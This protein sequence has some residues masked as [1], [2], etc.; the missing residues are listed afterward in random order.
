MP[1]SCRAVLLTCIF[2]LALCPVC[3][4][5][6]VS[7]VV[8]AAED[9]SGEQVAFFETRIRPVLVAHCYECHSASAPVPK[10]GLLLDSRE[11]LR[12]GGDSGPVITLEDPSQSL[13][14]SAI[15][16]EGLEMPPQRRLP[17][18]AAADFE[19][20]IGLGAP[21]P[22]TETSLRNTP[23]IDYEK[24]LRFWAFQQP[25][26]HALP[27]VQNSAWPLNE[28]DRFV[29]RA[30]EQRGLRPAARADSRA[31]IRRA[32]FDLIGLPPAPEAVEQFAADPSPAAWAE[33]I[34]RLL[35]SPHYGERWGRYWLDLA[36]YAEDQAHTFKAR[37]YPQGYLY[38]DWVVGALNDDMPYD[39]FL[40][41]QIAADQMDVR[42]Q[43]RHRA[44]LGL[45][46][47]GPVYYQDNGEQDKALADEWD[48]R[49]D[50][51]M[52][53]TQGLTVGCARCHDHKY[54]PISMADYYGLAGIFAS[55]E[56]REVPV[57]ADDVV[58]ARQSADVAMQQQTLQIHRLLT[59]HA[60]AA[61]LRL[62][63]AIPPYLMT[64]W[65]VRQV[66]REQPQDDKLIETLAKQNNLNSELLNRWVAWLAEQ[67][68][69][70]AVGTP[71][72]Y[73]DAWRELVRHEQPDRD[74]SNDPA[75]VARVTAVAEQMQ[76]QVAALIPHRQTLRQQFGDDFAFVA[77]EDRVVIA[78]GTV[79]LGNLFDDRA[80]TTLRSA[81]ATDRFRSVATADSP[82]VDRIVQGW[83]R[84]TEIAAGIHFDFTS[85]GSDERQFGQI[86][87]DGW[88]E[89]GGI[90]TLGQRCESGLERTE[91]GIGIH[92][93]ALLTLDLDE[94]RLA[95]LI[96]PDQT[97]RFR[98]DRA[99]LNDDSLGDGGSVHVAV[100]ISRPHRKEDTYDAIL[101]GYVNGHRATVAENDRQYYFDGTLPEPLLAD[102]RF[103]SFDIELGPEARYLTIVSTG[104]GGSAAENSINSDHAVLSGARLE[105]VPHETELTASAATAA[106]DELP[107]EQLAQMRI[108]ATLLSE[109]FDD[110][111]VLALPAPEIGPL[112]D[113]EPAEQLRNLQ[114]DLESLRK[115]AESIAVTMAHS[116]TDGDSRDLPI[117][118]AGDPKKTGEPAPRGFPAVFTTGRRVPFSPTGSGRRELAAAVTD[119]GNPLTARVIAN[120]VWAGHFGSGIVRTLN[121]FGQLGDRPSHPELLDFLALELQL[122]GWSLKSL[123][124][125]I[126]L[127]AT[128]QQNCDGEAGSSE[129]DPENRLLWRTNRRRLD[130]EAWRDAVLSAAGTLDRT[131][132]GPSAELHESNRRR[133]LYGQISRHQLNDLL[134][135]FDFPDPNITA[136]ERTV[137]TVPLQQLF[138][139]NSQFVVDQARALAARLMADSPQDGARVTQAFQLLFGRPPSEREL[140]AALDFLQQDAAE[141]LDTLT[142]LEQY[143]QALLGT[144]EFA[145][146]D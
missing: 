36:R 51:L 11:A 85:L 9:L 139:L 71:R 138:V 57:V 102:G 14:L 6:R 103:V 110:R 72:P 49:V 22:R 143:C 43:H 83:G 125:R 35:A 10:G 88:S 134:R 95:G 32:S 37:M 114:Q 60:P 58:R 4:V 135:L 63:S 126:M 146:V 40:R 56:Y 127:S 92:A 33:V 52:R 120:R 18:S 47:L 39:Q 8:R 29:L 53:G 3:Q 50:T 61:R 41:L 105:Y 108:E 78:P 112:L 65:K 26:K 46:A 136:G 142:P 69:S 115:T 91:Q 31:L 90:R 145:F 113:P 62:V 107:P 55:S 129:T 98:V 20:W 17:E 54:D 38:R 77:A 87:N 140:Q 67:P 86:T 93:N 130:V 89:A 131:V 99:G 21:D 68:D 70:G 94:I 74:L 132:G 119:P 42:D 122:S 25:R 118:L 81:V 1:V 121:N 80:G 27:E 137:T 28:V 23:T 109:L 79:P 100:I 128:Y 15:R 101:A 59:A 19:H 44:A 48:D 12:R 5:C 13:L 123:H 141:S 24:G 133:T 97:L 111:G 96:P 124:R 34:D 30:M 76:Q 64:A 116:L 144:N 7:Q 16:Y 75:A 82:G 66:R 106:A 117:F 2:L 73:L 45:F 104:A 84:A